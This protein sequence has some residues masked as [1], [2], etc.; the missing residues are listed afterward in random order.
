[1]NF[2]QKLAIDLYRQTPL[3]MSRQH[4]FFTFI[5]VAV[6]AATFTSLQS[7]DYQPYLYIGFYLAIGAIFFLLGWTSKDHPEYAAISAFCFVQA[8]AH[9]LKGANLAELSQLHDL[10]QYY[11][12]TAAVFLA[13]TLARMNNHINRL[14]SPFLI[15]TPLILAFLKIDLIDVW[16]IGCYLRGSLACGIQFYYL[17]STG[18]KNHLQ[19][20]TRTIKLL[21]FTAISLGL[22][23]LTAARQELYMM[24]AFA[25]ILTSV[26]LV[27]RFRNDNNFLSTMQISKYHRRAVLPKS[28]GVYLLCLDLKNSEEI[29][30]SIDGS[31]HLQQTMNHFSEILT[32]SGAEILQSEGDEII[33]LWET[34]QENSHGIL[35]ALQSCR[36]ECEKVR[37]YLVQASV[38]DKKYQVRFRAALT[39][40]NIAPVWNL[41]DGKRIA[42]WVMAGEKNLFVEV[43]RLLEGEKG[44]IERDTTSLLISTEDSSHF[45]PPPTQILHKNFQITGKHGQKY[46]ALVLNLERSAAPNL[47]VA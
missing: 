33:C 14:T 42:S 15:G 8:T 41:S 35:Q 40:G 31:V 34:S 12:G 30:R 2:W 46:E 45:N 39:Y 6:A 16:L 7:W 38:V 3:K 9:V 29:L 13:F 32:Q 25:M 37:Q 44:I 26:L 5:A 17:H 1:M 4:F 47:R 20:Q 10:V 23:I 28:L 11:Q 36:K 43:K 24:N 21:A 18:K 22:L 19:D 27:V